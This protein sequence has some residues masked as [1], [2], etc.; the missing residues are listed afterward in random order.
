MRNA[1]VKSFKACHKRKESRFT[2]FFLPKAYFRAYSNLFIA[3]RRSAAPPPL[4][5]NPRHVTL[6][7]KR[8]KKKNVFER[9]SDSYDG[10][11]AR[12]TPVATLGQAPSL[13]AVCGR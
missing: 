11:R 7:K 12:L 9:V 1:V 6:V 4:F 5:K 13:A 10:C 2:S 8:W 3:C